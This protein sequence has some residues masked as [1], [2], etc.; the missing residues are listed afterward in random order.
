MSAAPT[1]PPL[2]TQDAAA[3][4]VFRAQAATQPAGGAPIVL[5]P[6]HVWR[7]DKTGAGALL[8]A[9]NLLLDTGRLRARGLGDVV[10]AGP[11][12]PGAA[13]RPADPLQAGSRD[14]PPTVLESVREMRADVLDLRS[15]AVP[16]TG[17][18]ATVDATF[19]PLLQAVAAARVGDL[20][21]AAGPRG[22]R[23][24]RR[25]RPGSGSCATPSASSPRPARTRW[26][27]PT[28]RCC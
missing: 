1:S 27:P 22:R 28:H 3:A 2:A 21:R 12:T 24:P 17:V 8:A 23:R 14:I 18:G 19:E 11:T 6:P 9:V 20:A 26:G 7:T 4:L 15:A 13:R 10:A 25:R 5:A 16:E